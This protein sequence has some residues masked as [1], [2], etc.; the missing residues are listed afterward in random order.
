MRGRV[1]YLDWLVGGFAVL[2]RGV[3]LYE[4]VITFRHMSAS[5]GDMIGLLTEDVKGFSFRFLM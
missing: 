1:E 4:R 5:N 2:Y 3:G